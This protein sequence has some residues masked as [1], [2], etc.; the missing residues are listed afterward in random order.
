MVRIISTVKTKFKHRISPQHLPKLVAIFRELV[1]HG[2]DPGIPRLN[3]D[4]FGRSPLAPLAPLASDYLQ[5]S[6]CLVDLARVIVKYSS[7]DPFSDLNLDEFVWRGKFAGI[8]IPIY[9]F[10]S[11]QEE[12]LVTWAADDKL[13]Q[14]FD[15]TIFEAFIS[16]GFGGASSCY[17]GEHMEEILRFD[18]NPLIIVP[19]EKQYGVHVDYFG[20]L[21]KIINRDKE[22]RERKTLY[23][24][25][26]WPRLSARLGEAVAAY[27]RFCKEEITII[28]I[29]KY[30]I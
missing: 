14:K 1:G 30:K 5:D 17:F 2:L 27:I 16:R 28:K 20:I 15:N 12:W 6:E 4:K 23:P 25:Y 10:L 3:I 22:E 29:I 21:E 9:S 24:E 11:R 18:T 26:R 8:Q 7:Q 13:R 19:P